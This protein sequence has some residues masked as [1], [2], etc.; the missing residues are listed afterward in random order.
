MIKRYIL[1][2][3]LLYLSVICSILAQS[4]K[5]DKIENLKMQPQDMPCEFLLHQERVAKPGI[6]SDEQVYQFWRRGSKEQDLV[7][8]EE[9]KQRFDNP[10]GASSFQKWYRGNKTGEK[11]KIEVDIIICMSDSEIEKTITYFTKEAFASP[12]YKTESPF[13]GEKSW[14]PKYEQP[15]RDNFTVM[16]LKFNVFARVY[17][18]LK[19]KSADELQQMAENLAK[20]IENKIVL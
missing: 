20:I 13:A 16:F 9:A 6:S 3:L 18:R 7:L 11:D 17:V 5:P 8:I 19:D 2:S 4:V 1:I 14:M 15:M 12:F 10:V